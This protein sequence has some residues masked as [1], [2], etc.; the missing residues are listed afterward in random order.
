VNGEPLTIRFLRSTPDGVGVNLAVKIA[1]IGQVLLVED[2]SN[3]RLMVEILF[4][5]LGLA[6][7]SVSNGED[8][9]ALLRSKDKA[10]PFSLMLLDIR[11]HG[12][13][14][15]DVLRIVRQEQ[16]DLHVVLLTGSLTPD[17][18]N[19]TDITYFE[20]CLKPL[21]RADLLAIILKHGLIHVGAL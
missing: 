15:L 7:V 13:S 19:A 9:I 3:D 8:A 14:G 1:P 18:L 17:T 5:S 2:D 20:V 10:K 11:L 6:L 21:R 12:I 4:H 16:P